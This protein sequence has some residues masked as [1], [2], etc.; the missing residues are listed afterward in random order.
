MAKSGF[1]GNQHRRV[2]VTEGAQ[3]EV[4]Q[5]GLIGFYT[6]HAS[7]VAGNVYGAN[8]NDPLGFFTFNEALRGL[9]DEPENPWGFVKS[10]FKSVRKNGHLS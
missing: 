6:I 3:L 5:C 8:M 9:P 4:C 7:A 1:Y 10:H 2:S